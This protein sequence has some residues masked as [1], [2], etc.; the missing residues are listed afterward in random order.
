MSLHRPLAHDFSQLAAVFHLCWK[1]PFSSFFFF[2]QKET[3]NQDF[4]LIVLIFVVFR[5]T[6]YRFFMYRFCLFLVQPYKLDACS[7]GMHLSR[8]NFTW[9]FH[10]SNLLSNFEQIYYNCNLIPEYWWETTKNMG[11]FNFH[12]PLVGVI[13]SFFFVLDHRVSFMTLLQFIA[14]S[15]IFTK[16]LYIHSFIW[17]KHECKCSYSSFPYLN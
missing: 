4:F 15:I 13:L 14:A 6:L 3:K 1:F 7:I 10:I 17:I 8:H 16:I 11:F 12:Q 9:I 2:L 5:L